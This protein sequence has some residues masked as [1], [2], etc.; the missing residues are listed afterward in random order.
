MA[1]MTLLAAGVQTTVQDV[2]GRTGLW[3]VGVPPSG[4]FDELTMALLNAS[5]GNDLN[6]A[7][8]ECVLHGPR[9]TLDHDR[10][11]C[12]GG[13]ADDHLAAGDGP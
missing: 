11:V 13:A 1:G 8:L 9:L 2:L 7:G 5:V 10:L 12:V 4:A 3:D 6:A